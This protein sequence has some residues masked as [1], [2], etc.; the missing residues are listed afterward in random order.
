MV[1]IPV[2]EKAEL[3][4]TRHAAG[5]FEFSEQ[6]LACVRASRVNQDMTGSGLD[7]VAVH[8]PHAQGQREG[9]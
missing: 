9:D 7:Q 1:E 6:L 3:E 8:P 4:R 5:A 2:R